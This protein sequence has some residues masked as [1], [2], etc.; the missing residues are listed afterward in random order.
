MQARLV[1]DGLPTTL[2]GMLRANHFSVERYQGLGYR[3]IGDTDDDGGPAAADGSPVGSPVGSDNLSPQPSSVHSKGF[4]V[5]CV[6][7]CLLSS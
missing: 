4:S 5:R 6:D 1:A 7:A 3:T 2:P